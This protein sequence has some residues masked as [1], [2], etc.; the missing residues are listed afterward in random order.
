[1]FMQITTKIQIDII[2]FLL[3]SLLYLFADQYKILFDF[4]IKYKLGV[5]DYKFKQI[6]TQSFKCLSTVIKN[7]FRSITVFHT[8]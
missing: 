1:M 4:K 3:C 2:P 6:V 8:L 5:N 7:I